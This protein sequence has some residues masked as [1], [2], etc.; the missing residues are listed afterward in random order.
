MRIRP[1]V[2]WPI[3]SRGIPSSSLT[4]STATAPRRYPFAW[5]RSARGHVAPTP[6][7][8]R[9][10]GSGG[11]LGNKLVN[12]VTKE[13]MRMV[14]YYT[15]EGEKRKYMWNS[16]TGQQYPCDTSDPD[17]SQAAMN[18]LCTD[19]SYIKIKKGIE[20]FLHKRG[21]K[22]YEDFGFEPRDL[23]ELAELCQCRIVVWIDSGSFRVCRHDTDDLV[24]FNGIY[25]QRYV[26]NYH[27]MSD[28]HLE[29]LPIECIGGVDSRTLISQRIS[30]TRSPDVTYLDDAGFADILENEGAKPVEERRLYTLSKCIPESRKVSMGFP[31][32]A[33]GKQYSG[34]ILTSGERV[35]KHVALRDWSQALIDDKTLKASRVATCVCLADVHSHKLRDIYGSA[36]ISPIRQKSNPRLYHAAR[37]ADMQFGHVQLS[38]E[39]GSTMYEY[40][41]RKWYMADFSDIPEE[42]FPYFHGIPYSN[43]WSEYDGKFSD[44]HFVP[45]QGF[46]ERTTMIGNYP[47]DRKFTF[48]RGTKYAIFQIEELDLSGVS[49]STRAHFERDALFTDFDGEKSVL[50]LP[51]PIVHFLQDCGAVWRASRVWVCYGCGPYWVPESKESK[52]LSKEMIQKKTYP[53]VMGRLMCG[54]NPVDSVTYI[55]PDPETAESLQY[56]YSTQFAHGRLANE[57]R[58]DPAIIFEGEEHEYDSERDLREDTDPDA[59]IYSNDGEFAGSSEPDYSLVRNGGYI[60]P[61]IRAEEWDGKCPFYVETYHSTYNWGSTYCHISGAQH[62]MCFVRLYQAVVKMDPA[63]VTGFSLDS[64][65]TSADV[66]DLIQPFF[67]DKPGYFKPVEERPY[68]CPMHRSGSMLSDLYTPR[69]SFIGVNKAPHDSPMWND[70]KDSLRQF[71]IVTGSAGSGKTTRHFR[72]YEKGDKDYRLP[73]NTVYMTMTNHLAH[74]IQSEHKVDSFTS[75][76]GFNRRVLDDNN[77]IEASKRYDKAAHMASGNSRWNESLSK[78][79]NKHTVLLD[80]VSMIDPTKILDI[81]EVCKHYHVQL[82]IVGDLD[83][84]TFYQLSPVGHKAK[85]FYAALDKGKKNLGIDFYWVPPM[86]V[87]RQTGDQELNDLLASLREMDGQASWN[88]LYNSPIIRHVSY[89]EMLEE[90]DPS[91]DLVAQPWHRVIGTVTEDVLAKMR[92][93]DLLKLRGNFSAPKKLTDFTPEILDRLKINESDTTVFKGSTCLVTKEEL[94]E[95]ADTPLMSKGFP[96]AGSADDPNEVNP[97]VGATIFNLQGLTLDEDATIYI[98]TEATGFMDWIDRKQPKLAYVAASRAR[99]RAQIVIVDGR[100]GDRSSPREASVRR[101]FI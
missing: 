78:L 93:E 27:M 53:V 21:L 33:L 56:F 87:F 1:S 64:I 48:V 15:H 100:R 74:H 9:P 54:R 6:G 44:V 94:E 31:R 65:R 70:Y 34:W 18:K 25:D 77:F 17:Y 39:P 7:T 63:V 69:T 4:C 11:Y 101:R 43:T 57:A 13:M 97:M 79:E 72:R 89:E 3:R 96:Y 85:D 51:S 88:A 2:R 40:D 12:C 82:L 24:S 38:M 14:T 46:R 67:G 8:G 49:E 83:R 35:F 62:A 37:W 59:I 84:D 86:K 81:L 5:S 95:L 61:T 92:P 22:V 68:K 76:K 41:G 98:Y 73:L 55:A 99:R 32:E 26:F 29:L 66:S 58:I 23:C 50:M 90:I 45:G 20:A 91:K 60:T 19:K 30:P 16:E 28:Q 47:G 75:F 71:N 36:N 42:E 80:E 52:K 10:A